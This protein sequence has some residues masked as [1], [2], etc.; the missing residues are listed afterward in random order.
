MNE[1]LSGYLGATF[2]TFVFLSIRIV[3]KFKY[4]TTPT[5]AILGVLIWYSAIWPIFWLDIL[6]SKPDAKA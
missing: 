3:W 5:W 2:V 1:L 6:L 4:V